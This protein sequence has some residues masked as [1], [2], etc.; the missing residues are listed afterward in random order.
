MTAE[1]RLASGVFVLQKLAC[2]AG[3]RWSQQGEDNPKPLIRET[4]LTTKLQL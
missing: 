2:P 3:S 1:K 4:I